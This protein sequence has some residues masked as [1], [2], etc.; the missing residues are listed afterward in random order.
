LIPSARAGLL[1]IDF[2]R[3]MSHA[4]DHDL[5]DWLAG[6][7]PAFFQNKPETVFS[8]LRDLC[9]DRSLDWYIRANATDAVIAAA[10]HRSESALEHA[11]DW[12]ARIAADEQEDWDLR[13]C[14]G[15]T[16]LN[17]PRARNRALLDDLAVR[18]S[19]WGV[20][21]SADEV[22]K[23]YREMNE[24]PEWERFKN[25]W[26]FYDP[27]AIEHRRQRWSAET[28]VNKQDELDEA[29]W[30]GADDV[31]APYIREIPKIGRND[32]CPCGSGKKYKKCCLQ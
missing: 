8:S 17:F 24:Q 16:L 32:P 5:L 28:M 20:H 30:I 22:Q 23:I 18:Q 29:D 19:G 11:L 15:N 2:M 10:Q 27:E 12:L 13:L 1:L 7:W 21:F 25:P 26:Q 14:C 6:Y 4:D 9:E 31:W 3:S